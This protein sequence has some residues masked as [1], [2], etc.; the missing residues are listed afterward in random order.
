MPTRPADIGR[1]RFEGRPCP[2]C[3]RIMKLCR[4]CGY[5]DCYGCGLADIPNRTEHILS[6]PGGHRMIA[7]ALEGF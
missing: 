7:S 3:G 2:V 6:S 1:R 5:S 4:V